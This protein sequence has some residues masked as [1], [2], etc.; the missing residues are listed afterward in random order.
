AEGLGRLGIQR[1]RLRREHRR[2]F[3]EAR[4]CPCSEAVLALELPRLETR[5]LVGR[6]EVELD[7]P[8]ILPCGPFVEGGAGLWSGLRGGASPVASGIV[9]RRVR[10][11]DR[12]LVPAGQQGACPRR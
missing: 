3:R 11:P 1:E 2:V 7:G 9:R 12:R 8:E 10:L 5:A 4:R 6:G